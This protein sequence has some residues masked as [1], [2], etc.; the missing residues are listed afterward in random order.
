MTVK[1]V[2][3]MRNDHFRKQDILGYWF[4]LLIV[5]VKRCKGQSD[6]RRCNWSGMFALWVDW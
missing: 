1:K 5:P 6:E 2:T 4:G 3:V